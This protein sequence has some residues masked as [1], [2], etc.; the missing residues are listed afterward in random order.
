MPPAV[1][2]RH[3]APPPQAR[4]S[5]TGKLAKRRDNKDLIRNKGSDKL[6]LPFNSRIC[7][8]RI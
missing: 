3:A 2:P 1:M 7:S 4:N 8:A 6:V 5:K